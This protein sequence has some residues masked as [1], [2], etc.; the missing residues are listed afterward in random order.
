MNR[1]GPRLVLGMIILVI[2][3]SIGVDLLFDVHLHL[4]RIAI[5]ALFV[6]WGSWLVVSAHARRDRVSG[7]R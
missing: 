7:A 3:A 4:F 6:L 5:A 2:G 1:I